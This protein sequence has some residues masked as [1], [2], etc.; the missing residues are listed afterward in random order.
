MSQS[1]S[2]PSQRYDFY[3]V[4][5]LLNRK[6]AATKLATATVS[7]IGMVLILLVLFANAIGSPLL[8]ISDAFALGPYLFLAALSAYGISFLIFRTSMFGPVLTA[9][10]NME[11]QNAADFLLSSGFGGSTYRWIERAV[12]HVYISVVGIDG[13]VSIPMGRIA[14]VSATEK[15]EVRI[16]TIKHHSR[17]SIMSR[18]N[19]VT[20][21]FKDSSQAATF[22]ACF[23][24]LQRHNYQTAANP[25]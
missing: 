4:E 23:D 12:G 25:N 9:D 1:T 8:S 24:Q 21:R 17:W 11:Y 2:E 19:A 10:Q 14:S 22:V 20:L 3:G 5:R 7:L 13:I 18:Q 15:F 16:K 6:A